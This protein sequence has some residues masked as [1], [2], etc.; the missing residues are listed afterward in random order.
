MRTWGKQLAKKDELPEDIGK[1]L[2]K[3]DELLE[4]MRKR[5]REER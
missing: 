1:Q 4:D 5:T 3:K 2:V